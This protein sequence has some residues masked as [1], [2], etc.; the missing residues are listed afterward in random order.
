MLPHDSNSDPLYHKRQ[1]ATTCWSV[2]LR[3]GAHPSDET[4]RALTELIYSYWY[5]LYA[6]ARRQGNGNDDAL[7]LTQGFFAHLLDAHALESVSPEKGR[8][9]SFL[10][11]SFQNFMANQRRAAMAVRRGGAVKILSLTADDFGTRF[12]REPAHHETPELCFQRSWVEALLLKVR[13]R[14]AADYQQAG[15]SELFALLEPHLTQQGEVVP[16]AEIGRRLNLSPAAVA[17][18][19]HRMRRRY[20][21]ILRQEVAATVD[22]PAEVDDE[23][24]T[25]M[26]II[27]RPAPSQRERP[28]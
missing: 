11:A 20:G 16:R 28:A 13:S 21:E 12:D 9:R 26:S 23:L 15:K 4:H 6:F 25:L 22:N 17:M 24:R 27:S 10:L 2:V 18:S 14:L 1:F 7:D 5:P 8:F 3:A 19:I